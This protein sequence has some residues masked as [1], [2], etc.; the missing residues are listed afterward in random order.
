[1]DTARKIDDCDTVT[2]IESARY[3]FQASMADHGENHEVR[4]INCR[5]L[6]GAG[7][8]SSPVFIGAVLGT[9]VVYNCP[10]LSSGRGFNAR[11]YLFSTR[12]RAPQKAAIGTAFILRQGAISAVHPRLALPNGQ[13]LLRSSDGFWSNSR[14]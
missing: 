2:A 1:M 7:S 10:S 14:L 13:T 11:Y 12:R 3:R 8:F 5:V 6:V 9:T 4:Y